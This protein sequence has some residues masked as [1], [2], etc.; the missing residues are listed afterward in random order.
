MK[1]LVATS[2]PGKLNEFSEMLHDLDVE[3]VSLHE[4]GL[5]EMD[6]PET[7]ETFAE[8][9]I[10]KARAYHQASGL[11]TLADDSGLVVDALDGA[12]GVYSAR[13]GAPEVST[14]IGRYQKV[15]AQLAGV[16]DER[17]TARF[18]CVVAIAAPQQEIITVEGKVKGHIA[19]APRGENGFG[20]DPIF[21]LADGRTIAEMP[22]HEKHRISHRGHAL[23]AAL[24]I[25][26][27]LI[28]KMRI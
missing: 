17:R 15:L 13:Y 21:Q 26:Q 27:A 5:A 1:L 11:L 16:P 8:N 2:N 20:Y 18:V 28:N 6:V 3:W 10:L 12:P 19:H 24:P 7:G 25:L 14:D 22:S 4:V 9:A 23:R